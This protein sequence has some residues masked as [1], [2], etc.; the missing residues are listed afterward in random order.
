MAL[1][2][3]VLCKQLDHVFSNANLHPCLRFIENPTPALKQQL[4][5]ALNANRHIPYR[6][7]H[8]QL[9]KAPYT[10]V[11]LNEK[12]KLVAGSAIK[13]L[14]QA[15]AEFGFTLVVPEYR[16]LGLGFTMTQ[17][18]LHVAEHLGANL[19]YSMIRDNNEKSRE[20]LK[21]SG[22]R[23]A[24]KYLSRHDKKTRLDWYIKI[25]QPISR[26]Q[27]QRIMRQVMAERI[28]VIH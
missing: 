10:L 1:S 24:G 16:R 19:V 22:F 12:G 4:V 3:P 6:V 7:E 25:L 28:A 13:C 9:L 11:I 20:N 15:A 18:R 5:E 2:N 21:K 27:R 8:D 23:F 26:Q 14:N 17:Q